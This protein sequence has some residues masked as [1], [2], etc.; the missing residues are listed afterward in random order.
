MKKLIKKFKAIP[1]GYKRLIIVGSII[2]PLIIALISYYFFLIDNHGIAVMR[3]YF[4]YG[5]MIYWV[6]TFIAIWVYDG[7]KP[8]E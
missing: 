6:L 8:I 7:F 5:F 3:K 1:S 2:L 4:S